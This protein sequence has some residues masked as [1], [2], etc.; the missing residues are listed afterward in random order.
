[1][2]DPAARSR[3]QGTLVGLTVGDAIG[4]PA[5]GLTVEQIRAQWGWIEGF[6]VD[7]PEGSDDTEY[8]LYTALLLLE[9][10]EQFTADH[11]ADAWLRDVCRQDGAFRGSGF[12]EMSAIRNLLAGM[13]P[14]Y[15]GL[16]AHSFS[17]GL[18]MRVAPLGVAAIGDPGSAARLAAEDG[19]VSHSGEGIY[20][21]Q[22]VAAVIAAGV[23]GADL[24]TSL[25]E[26]LALTPSGWSSRAIE[27][28]IEVGR[29]S[30]NE[31]ELIDE[32]HRQLVQRRYFWADLA[33]EAVAIAVAAVVFSEGSLQRSILAC[34]NTGRD[35]DTSAAI[36][37]AIAGASGGIESVPTEWL[38]VVGPL[39]GTC[40]RVARG[41]HPIE[42]ADRLVDEVWS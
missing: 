1:M 32:I 39:G 29:S 21:G 17:D 25:R 16:H 10:R 2:N 24:M 33:P 14:P 40:L 20:S 22:F 36:A 3:A 9:L 15:S 38:T 41:L 8:A 4:R 13:R 5:E 30:R 18:A 23:A 19:K 27:R 7:E 11:I 26:G 31:T 37:G 42:M 28:A 34:V 6:V 12:S 35:A